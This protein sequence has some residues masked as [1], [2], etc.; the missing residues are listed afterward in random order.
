MMLDRVVKLLDRLVKVLCP[1]ST[2]IGTFVSCKKDPEPITMIDIF[3]WLLRTEIIVSDK[4]KFLRPIKLVSY[5]NLKWRKRK[6][7]KKSKKI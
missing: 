3:D 7:D 2:F 1:L 5:V 6:V 4:T